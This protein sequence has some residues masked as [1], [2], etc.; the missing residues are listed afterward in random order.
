MR[1][2]HRNA[3]RFYLSLQANKGVDS[4]CAPPLL[5]QLNNGILKPAYQTTGIVSSQTPAAQAA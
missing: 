4:S 5:C 2:H 3:C 1:Q